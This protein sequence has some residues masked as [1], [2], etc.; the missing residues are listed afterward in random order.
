MILINIYEQ[1]VELLVQKTGW[2]VELSSSHSDDLAILVTICDKDIL[3]YDYKKS[4]FTKKIE[5]SIK[6]ISKSNL[7]CV[8]VIVMEKFQNYCISLTRKCYIKQTLDI[9]NLVEKI[10][11]EIPFKSPEPLPKGAWI[12]KRY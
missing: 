12:R 11:K 7:E 4:T 2:K 10:I 8:D 5:Y 6:F 1:I 3:S 9:N